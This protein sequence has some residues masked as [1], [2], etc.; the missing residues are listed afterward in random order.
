MLQK[1]NVPSISGPTT[2]R[3]RQ[4][5]STANFA[6]IFYNDALCRA[7]PEPEI[8]HDSELEKR[9]RL[10]GDQVTLEPT[11]ID[12][13]WVTDIGYYYYATRKEHPASAAIVR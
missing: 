8:H 13:V 3:N 11:L 4:Y 9:N 7:T 6:R 5:N 12:P 2:I 10:E 1:R